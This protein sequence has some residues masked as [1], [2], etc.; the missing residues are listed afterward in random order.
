MSKRQNSAD[1]VGSARTS[2]VNLLLQSSWHSLVSCNP[3][4]RSQ[5]DYAN[6]T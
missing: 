1:R 6:K 3:L 5:E 2:A 4:S